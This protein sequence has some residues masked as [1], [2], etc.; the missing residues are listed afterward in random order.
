MPAVLENKVLKPMDRFDRALWNRWWSLAKPYWFSE[1]RWQGLSLLA[2]LIVLTALFIGIN[3]QLSFIWRNV[4]NALNARDY[5]SFRR[6]IIYVGGVFLV[7]IPL[8][9]FYPWF[10]GRLRVLWREWMTHHFIK[11]QFTDRA[12]YRIGQSGSVDNPDQRISEDIASFSRGALAYVDQFGT[13]L[14]NGLVFLVI[15]WTISPVLAPI[16]VAYCVVGTW[17]ST[18]VGRPLIPLN[19]DQQ[20]YEA[21]FRF[22]LVRVRDN[23][24]S[25]AMYSGE[26]RE[27]NHLLGRFAALFDNYNRLIFRQRRLA[28]VTQT[29]DSVVSLLPYLALAGAYFAHRMEF[30]QFLQAAGAFGT[31]KD[32]FSVVVFS[33]E[34]LT[35][36]A[37]VVNRLATFQEQCEDASLPRLKGEH[38]D[39]RESER[40]AVDALTLRTPDGRQTLVRDLSFD[41]APGQGLLLRGPS[42]TGKT[43]I[44]RALAGL[45]DNGKG[46]IERP[47][48]TNALFLP[49]KPYLMLG[50]LRDQLCYPRATGV[51]DD[52]LKG[53]L[54]EVN[55][56]DLPGRSGGLDVEVDWAS[57]LSPGEQQRL[58]FARLVI[59]HPRYVFLDEATAALDRTNQERLYRLLCAM[60]ITFVSVSHSPEIVEYHDQILELTGDA[61]WILDGSAKSA[62][63]SWSP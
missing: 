27:M 26:P 37:A 20:R 44:L 16:C 60:K 2:V 23:A 5:L 49:Q 52:D 47:E 14:V 17:V 57:M 8:Q 24:E 9:A 34:G 7:F 38:I 33:L 22:A 4:N 41:V 59:N 10:S 50:T 53:A 56:A 46:H 35:D 58:A 12:Y 13:A 3:A 62:V 25:I 51:S 48:L 42:G 1:K 40:I 29:Y 61:H 63:K 43:S 21:D 36:Y 45:W 6:N 15:L 28:Y 18:K 54:N 32:S 31:V 55:L 39:T 19:F 11:L 30:G